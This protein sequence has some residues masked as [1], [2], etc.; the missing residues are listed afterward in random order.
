LAAI[1]SYVPRCRW[2]VNALPPSA[3][4]AVLA[5]TTYLSGATAPPV[6]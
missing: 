4:T 3:T 6:V 2:R 1:S 5:T